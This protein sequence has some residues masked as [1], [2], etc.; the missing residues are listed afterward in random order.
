[1]A[2]AARGLSQLGDIGAL[3]AAT[4]AAAVRP[5]YSYG[6]EFV[7]QSLLVLRLCLPLM[8]IVSVALTYGPAGVQAANF[9]GLFGALDRLGGLFVVVVIREFAPLVCAIVIAGV[10]GTAITADLG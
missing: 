2:G 5:P 9:L 7:R 1:M 8:V 3:T 4:L 6:R 10:A